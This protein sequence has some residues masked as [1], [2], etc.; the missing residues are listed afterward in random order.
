M[1]TE[2]APRAARSGDQ[3]RIFRRVSFAIVD[4]SPIASPSS[5]DA[6]VIR[7]DSVAS[8]RRA[9]CGMHLAREAPFAHELRCTPR[10][11]PDA[12][13]VKRAAK[14][15]FLQSFFFALRAANFAMYPAGYIGNG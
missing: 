9:P 10:G 8:E 7:N 14:A 3:L 4:R 2:R 11:A 12:P 13:R 6:V 15:G 1:A 5:V